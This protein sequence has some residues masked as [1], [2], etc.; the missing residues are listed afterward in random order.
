MPALGQNHSRAGQTSLLQKYYP[1]LIASS[2]MLILYF[3]VPCARGQQ[4]PLEYQQSLAAVWEGLLTA[5]P[6]A[7]GAVAA[8]QGSGLVF[9]EHGPRAPSWAVSVFLCFLAQSLHEVCL[10][11]VCTS[12]LQTVLG[13][14]LFGISKSSNTIEAVQSRLAIIKS[15]SHKSRLNRYSWKGDRGG[16]EMDRDVLY[17]LKAGQGCTAVTGGKGRKRAEKDC[18]RDSSESQASDLSAHWSE[19]VSSVC[20]HLLQ[21]CSPAASFASALLHNC[22]LCCW[23][24]HPLPSPFLQHCLSG[25]PS[26]Q[27]QPTQEE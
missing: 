8:A 1:H 24:S 18:K 7:R 10:H 2:P 17:C 12:L 14:L 15:P 20:W 21:P 19:T 27:A 26:A 22:P 25:N 23:L 16:G 6:S 4:A 9:S 5:L 3:Q 13:F 11:K